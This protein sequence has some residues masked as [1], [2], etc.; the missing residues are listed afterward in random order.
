MP[1][2]IMLEIQNP[3]QIHVHIETTIEHPME[4]HHVGTW[5]APPPLPPPLGSGLPPPNQTFV[6]YRNILGN[7][8]Y[9]PGEGV[10]EPR[11]QPAQILLSWWSEPIRVYAEMLE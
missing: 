3:L 11:P 2:N 7:L 5:R 8:R 10:R 6:S 1:M 9:F 4:Y